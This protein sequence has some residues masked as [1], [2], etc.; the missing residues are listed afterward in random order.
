MLH[1]FF[2]ADGH[3][4][5][6]NNIFSLNMMYPKEND[7]EN[8]L[9]MLPGSQNEYLDELFMIYWYFSDSF[10]Q[11]CQYFIKDWSKY[12]YWEPGNIKK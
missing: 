10:P 1:D 12:S 9:L 4:T 7:M 8:H 6:T 5:D 11:K 3:A 2:R